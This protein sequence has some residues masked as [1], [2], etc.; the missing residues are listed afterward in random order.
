MVRSFV[1]SVRAKRLEGRQGGGAASWRRG[2]DKD[3]E[4]LEGQGRQWRGEKGK[5]GEGGRGGRVAEVVAEEVEE[6][7][8]GLGGVCGSN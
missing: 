3:E 4:G 7:G 2:T 5:E 8:V 1:W 6:E